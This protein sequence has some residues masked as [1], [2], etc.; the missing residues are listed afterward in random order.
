MTTWRA[1]MILL[2]GLTAGCSAS[3]SLDDGDDAVFDDGVCRHT[4]FVQTSW[5]ASTL[6]VVPDEVI[7]LLTTH[8]DVPVELDE[9]PVAEDRFTW[10]FEPVDRPRLVELTTSPNIPWESS[11]HEGP[12]LVIPLEV[13]FRSESGL[14]LS[15]YPLW[16]RV[17]ED[18]SIALSADWQATSTSVPAIWEDVVHRELADDGPSYVAR[19]L[20]P[21]LPREAASLDELP[22]LFEG[23]SVTLVADH[24]LSVLFTEAAYWATV[25]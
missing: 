25:D 1:S 21:F 15:P 16:V 11:C 19:G 7:E 5:E 8:G 12:A 14:S 17:H 6:G 18:G 9:G 20:Y 24:P 2:L 13:S 10:T 23:G 4:S 3:P 22:Q